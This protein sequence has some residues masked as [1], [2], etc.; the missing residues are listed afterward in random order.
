M[1]SRNE[2]CFPALRNGTHSSLNFT[3]IELLVVIVIIAILASMLLP[4]LNKAR[5][6]AKTTS[7]LSTHKMLGQANAMYQTDY[8]GNYMAYWS[9]LPGGS[10]SFPNQLHALSLY[11]PKENC[12][13]SAIMKDGTRSK[14]AC[15]AE[16][17]IPDTYLVSIGINT[18]WGAS[19]GLSTDSYI[20]KYNNIKTG[21]YRPSAFILFG[22]VRLTS[23]S[24]Y[25]IGGYVA[26]SSVK[27]RHNNA[28]VLCY[29]DGHAGVLQPGFYYQDKDYVAQVGEANFKNLIKN[30]QAARD[31][32][33]SLYP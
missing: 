27:L 25:V 13:Y 7:C 33:I 30:N 3:L 29:G 1:K 18:A 23:A 14:Y 32:W 28:G 9:V 20:R 15:P 22:D 10:A 26:Y 24:N 4:S 5:D 31:F 21:F 11:V 12:S 17:G 8:N 2:K 6:K 16:P 19:D